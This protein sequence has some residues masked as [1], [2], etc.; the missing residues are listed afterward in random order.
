MHEISHFH[1]ICQALLNG[2]ELA[3]ASI[4]SDKGSTPR[5]SGSKMIVY[6]D[7]DICGT[8]GGGAVEGDVIQRALRLFTTGGAEIASYDLNHNGH[9]EQMDLLCGGRMKVLIEHVAVNDDNINLFGLAHEELKMSRPFWWIGKIT[10]VDGKLQ[11]EHAI[12]TLEKGV[13]GPHRFEPEIQKRMESGTHIRNGS[14]FIELEKHS[15]VIE[16]IQPPETLFLFGAGHVAKEIASLSKKVGFRIMVFD[17]RADFA[18]AECFPDADEIIVC[19]EYAGVFDGVNMTPDDF[20]VIVTRG[21]RF[22]KEV[23]AQALQTEAGYIGMIG[24]RRKKE[25]IY[26]ELI[27]QGAKQSTLE[28][29]CCPVGLSIDAET[30]AEIGVS[31]VAQMIQQRAKRRNHESD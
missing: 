22:D 16:S 30:P 9:A 12:Q 20:I 8:I 19:P 13:A 26:K 29:V 6:P 4:I 25:A 21:H 31:V 10:D 18:N 5:S 28:Q 14:W 24:S 11:V 3:V 27:H 17:D 1:E 7:G 15:Y 2:Q 23:L